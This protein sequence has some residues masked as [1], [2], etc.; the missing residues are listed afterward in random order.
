MVRVQH[1][2]GETLPG[3][4]ASREKALAI[5]LRVKGWRARRESE[6]V[7]VLMKVAINHWRE[8]PL[9]GSVLALRK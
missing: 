7:V 5:N 1:G 6:G 9:L 4:G 8:G 2:T 3:R